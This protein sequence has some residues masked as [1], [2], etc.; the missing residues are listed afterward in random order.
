VEYVIGG[1]E[2]HDAKEDETWYFA[3][4]PALVSGWGDTEVE[5][6]IIEET[7]RPILE[8][9]DR[10]PGWRVTL[11]MQGRMVAV[12]AERHPGVLGLLQKLA[13]RGQVELV[14][15]HYSAQLFLAFP[16]QDLE[17]SIARTKAV[18]AEHCLPLSGVVFNQEGQAGE[19]RQQMLV[20]MGYTV[21]V[22]P[23]NLYRYVQ[24]D[25]PWW[26]VYES[27]GGKLIVGPGGVDPASGVE[28]AWHFFDDGELR[29]VEKGM[30]PYFAPLAPANADRIAAYEAELE[31]LEADGWKITTITDYVAQLDAL[32]VEAKPAPPLLDGTWQ[33][34]STESIHRW[35]GGRS[36]VWHNTEEDTV[37][38]S[39]N[40]EARMHTDATQVLYEHAQ[41]EG[42]DV[43]PWDARMFA[44]WEALWRAQVSDCTGVNPWPGEVIFGIREN[45]WLLSET[46]ALRQEIFTALGV[47]HA[48]VDL[49]AR[50]VTPNDG[51]PIA[52]PPDPI[53]PPLDV[54]ILADNREVA[55]LWYQPAASTARVEIEFSAPDPETACFGACDE[56]LLSVRFPRTQDL[57]AYSPGLI[58]DEVTSY[59]LSD[60][61]FTEGEAWLPLAN[62]LIGLGDGVWVI[63]HTRSNHVAARI[64]PAVATIDFEDA[65]IPDDVGA[66]WAFDVLF[67]ASP[68]E[69]LA[70][71]N[72]LNVDPIVFY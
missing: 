22:Y 48:A 45:E 7:F 6:Y 54:E 13:Q 44:L 16:R 5:D 27:R 8:V 33:P 62:G 17:R 56:R 31:A 19:G 9:Y 20:D 51:P 64:S 43:S 59:A 35:L 29:A 42:A 26:P 2:Y 71:A 1:L 66:T 12:M 18:F 23:K 50:T 32:G 30:N 38:R 37:V 41:A 49:R 36:Q 61:T 68:E 3:D 25:D 47:E 60:F 28:V 14:S 46:A 52:E 34:P 4:Q 10:H 53:E 39:G 63:K 24:G 21:G 65:T 70:Y 72:R 55:T 15:F 57:I 69:A 11:E 58:E 67:D 40:A